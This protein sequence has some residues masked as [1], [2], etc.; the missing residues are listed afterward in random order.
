ME[1]VTPFI[2]FCIRPMKLELTAVNEMILRDN[3]DIFRKNGFEFI[4]EDEGMVWFY[5][6]DFWVKIF[7]QSFSKGTVQY[8]PWP[9]WSESK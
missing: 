8:F 5:L 4:F 7:A 1:K 6:W 9:F 2:Y 3:L